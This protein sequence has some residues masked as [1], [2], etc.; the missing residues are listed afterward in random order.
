MSSKRILII[1]DEENMLHMLKTILS[2]EGY[3]IVTAGNGIEG[4]EKIETNLFDTILCDLRMPEMDGLSFLKTVKVKNIDSTIIMMSAYGTI[5]LAVEAMK[6]GAYD[7]I[8]KPFKPDEIILNLRKAEERERLRKENILLKKEIKKEF[9]FE[10]II[11]KND[12]MLQIFET[13]HKISDYDTSILI[14]GESGTGKELVAKAIHYNSKRSGKPF[15]AINCGAIPENLLE[16]ELF[17][18]VKGAFT[19]ANQNKKGLFEEANGGTLLLDEIGELPSNLQVKLLRTLQEGEVRKVGDTKQIKLDVR[20]IAATS[21]NLGQ[22]VRSNSFREDLFYRLNVIQIDLPPLRER[23]EDIPLL[24]NHFLNRYNEKHHLKAKNISSAAL[25]ILVEYDW[26]GNIR[27][28]E[29]AIERAVILSE[30][31]RIEVS[32]LPPDIRKLKAP[33]EK[34]M[35]NDEYSIKR[36]H[37]IMEEQLIKKALDKTQG[38]RTR[39]ARLLEISHPSLLSK[40]KEFRIR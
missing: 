40:M 22:E 13:I 24:I 12:K 19:D 4:L 31:S 37:L 34:E 27:E 39:A 6:H 21:K 16:S 10:N 15:V 1:D 33:R 35:V 28:L 11:T 25:N 32:A 7:Y 23:R 29:N 3:E 36:I 30:G 8:S 20:I 18:Y 26:Q 2:K 9:C 17:G 5:D 14:L 38:N